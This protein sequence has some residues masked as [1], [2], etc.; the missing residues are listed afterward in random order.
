MQFLKFDLHNEKAIFTVFTSAFGNSLGGRRAA[1]PRARVTGRL[2]KSGS[3]EKPWGEGEQT[4][5]T[6]EREQAAAAA[7]EVEGG[8]A[9]DERATASKH[10]KKEIRIIFKGYIVIAVKK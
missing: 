8:V 6:T 2:R 9:A 7:S 3:W 1:T 5:Q 4:R 10:L